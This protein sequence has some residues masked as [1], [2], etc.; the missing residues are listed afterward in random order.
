MEESKHG[1]VLF[2]LGSNAKATDLPKDK[3]TTLLNV[4]SKLEQRVLMKW[5]SDVLPNQPKNVK[6]VK[7]L[8]QTDILSKKSFMSIYII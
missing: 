6:I 8:P 7:W 1:V 4:F 5:E 3:L 2:S